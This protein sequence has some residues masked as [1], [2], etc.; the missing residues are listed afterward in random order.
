MNQNSNFCSLAAVSV[1]QGDKYA[2]FPVTA[3]QWKQ[4]TF[5]MKQ[6]QQEISVAWFSSDTTVEKLISMRQNKK[7]A[8]D[9]HAASLPV[10]PSWVW[11]HFESRAGMADPATDN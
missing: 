1:N 2:A 7:V 5:N 9:W 8:L 11:R 6:Q 4:N 10:N 3:S